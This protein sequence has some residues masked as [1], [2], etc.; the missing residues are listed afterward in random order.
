MKTATLTLL[1]VLLSNTFYS[2][3]R[4]EIK[5]IGFSIG[6][7]KK[8]LS[9]DNTEVLNNLNNYDFTDK[10]INNLLKADNA[11]VNLATY[12]KYDPK[13]YAGII[14]TIKIR[15]R[16]NKTTNLEDFLNEVQNSNIEAKK[17]LDDFRFIENPTIVELS[18]EK[19]VKFSVQFVLKNN[20]K[21]H[22]INSTSYY[23]PKNGYYISINFIEE[24]G[25]E[26]NHELFEALIE[27][28]SLTK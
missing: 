26:N 23:I 16:E 24:Y 21:T 5:R 14:P 12:V 13:T 4:L 8:W 27:G 17:S 22:I 25:K 1:F 20:N 28:V 6:I 9:Q 19:V 18:K 15:T 10:Q 2:Q 3:E 7:P 11:S